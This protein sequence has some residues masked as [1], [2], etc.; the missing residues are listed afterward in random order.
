MPFFRFIPLAVRYHRDEGRTPGIFCKNRAFEGDSCR[1]GA[2]TQNEV[3]PYASPCIYSKM[4][5]ALGLPQ[6]R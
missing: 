6:Q 2:V 4:P 5:W 3:Q 1:W